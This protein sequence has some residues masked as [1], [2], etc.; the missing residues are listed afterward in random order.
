MRFDVVTSFDIAPREAL[1][2]LHEE[3]AREYPDYTIHIVP[4]VDVSN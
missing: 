4:D 1:R 2:I 3:L